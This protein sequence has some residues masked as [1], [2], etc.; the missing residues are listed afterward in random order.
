[1]K[2]KDKFLNFFFVYLSSA[3]LFLHFFFTDY[4]SLLHNKNKIGCKNMGKVSGEKLES[5]VVMW[6][7][8][9]DKGVEKWIDGWHMKVNNSSCKLF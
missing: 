5:G 7:L 9:Q 6:S 8:G 3:I 4:N 2:K 1:M